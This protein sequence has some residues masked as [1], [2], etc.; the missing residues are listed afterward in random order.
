LAPKINPKTVPDSVASSGEAEPL[1]SK[2]LMG[3]MLSYFYPVHYRVGMDLE[4]VMC[5]GRITRKQAAI[6]WLVHSRADDGNWV[7][8]KEIDERLS[9]WFE[10]SK[11]N[12]SKIMRELTKPPLSLVIQT[13]NPVSGRE[14]VVKLTG[15]GE[16]FVDSMNAAA[17]DHLRR[18]FNELTEQELRRGVNFMKLLF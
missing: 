8:R 3:E 4:I 13:E 9:K 18:T 2:E 1:T 10:I 11:S 16:V 12:I 14:K 17:I 15:E 5:Q 6:L 7:S